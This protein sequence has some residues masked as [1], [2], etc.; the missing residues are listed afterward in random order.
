MRQHSITPRYTTKN[1]EGAMRP[2]FGSIREVASTSFVAPL[3]GSMVFMLLLAHFVVGLA[4]FLLD[5]AGI[6]FDV[7]RQ[8]ARM[9]AGDLAGRLFRSTFDFVLRTFN[10]IFIHDVICLLTCLIAVETS[11]ASQRH[12]SVQS[13]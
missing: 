10:A 11:C 4:N 8:L 1:K 2:L 5:L 9:I 12:G 3:N 7:A 13:G 6:F